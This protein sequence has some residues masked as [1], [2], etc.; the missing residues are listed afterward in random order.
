MLVV[1]FFFLQLLSFID[2]DSSRIDLYA[3]PQN[4][5]ESIRERPVQGIWGA[6]SRVRLQALFEIFHPDHQVARRQSGP[7]LRAS[8]A[9]FGRLKAVTPAASNLKRTQAEREIHA[10]PTTLQFGL[11]NCLT[12]VFP[13]NQ[14]PAWLN[15]SARLPWIPARA[16]IS[17][18]WD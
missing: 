12:T 5:A 16:G 15:W 9:P 3:T 2:L 17:S 10:V 13:S 7:S 6:P 14:I 4:R 11:R 8:A 1:P 18:I